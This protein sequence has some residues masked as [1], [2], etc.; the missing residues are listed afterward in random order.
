MELNKNRDL[1]FSGR[2]LVMMSDITEVVQIKN[3]V[4]EA[5]NFFGYL[6][7]ERNFK[8]RNLG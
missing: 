6:Y 2:N 1:K 5:K 3:K 8:I 7:Q 4:K